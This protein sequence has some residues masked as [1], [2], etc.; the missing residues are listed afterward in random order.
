MYLDAKSGLRRHSPALIQSLAITAYNTN[1]YRQRHGGAYWAWR[2]YFDRWQYAPA[3]KW[4]HEQSRRLRYFISYIR[5]RSPYYAGILGQGQ[6]SNPSDLIDLPLLTKDDLRKNLNRITTV[7]ERGAIA[8]HTGGTTGASL[9]VLYLPADVQERFAILDHFRA[10][11]GY[12]FGRRT[13]WFSGKDLLNQRDIRKG[14]FWRD[15][16]KNSIRFFST[17]HIT[18]RNF[19]AYWEAL[20]RFSPEFI[21]GFPSSVHDLCYPAYTR[22]LAMGSPITTFF[23]TAET[24]LPQQ[25]AIIDAVLGGRTVNQ[26]ASSEGAPFIL[27]CQS[28]SLHM[29]PLTGV[30]EV[31]SENGLS[32]E[33]GELVVTPF[34]TR[35]TPLV[36]YRIGDRVRLGP[37]GQQC[38]CGSTFPVVERLEGRTTDCLDSP[39]TGPCNLGN[40]SNATKGV[41][42]IS[43]FQVIQE[44]SEAVSVLVV[45]DADFDKE[46]RERFLS[47][48]HDRLGNEMRVSLRLVDQPVRE[49]SGKVRLIKNRL[50]DG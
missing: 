18:E 28:G 21:V 1:Q 50:R 34:A 7:R 35:G 8:T 42:G 15:D 19:E 41:R 29:H 45:A 16:Y 3:E 44:E 4:Q 22:D 38:E 26:Y 49:S 9:K 40:L 37:K 11:Y 24:L 47:A 12:T 14:R 33:E 31:L 10:K 23:P 46:E 13:A 17:F 43:S 48:L 27:E 6:V 2:G 5:L 30:F 25:V 32:E 39:F 20:N 36:R